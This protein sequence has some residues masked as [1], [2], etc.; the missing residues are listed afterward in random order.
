MDDSTSE[1]LPE[2]VPESSGLVRLFDLHHGE[3]R[4]F[5]AVRCGNADDGE[6]L[7][8]DLWLK[9]AAIT[10]GPIANGRAYLF[11][12]ANN[13]MLDRLRSHQRAMRRDLGWIDAGFL[14]IGSP[15]ERPDFAAPADEALA[16]RQE[17]ALLERVIAGLPPG[18][19]WA[20]RLHRL[21]EMSQAEVAQTMGISRSG[22]EKHL[23]V[24]MKHLRRALQ[25]CGWYAPVTLLVEET[26]TAGDGTGKDK[27]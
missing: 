5:L 6:D 3:L 16:S 2:G 26:G 25:D 24:A 1:R 23:A 22:V 18:A 4:R 17:A 21:E 13:L 19:Q 20:L 14:G 27:P 9:V 8:Q 11:R 15:E 10:P 7:L 12:M